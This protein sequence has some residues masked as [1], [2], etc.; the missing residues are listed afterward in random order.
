MCAAHG[1]SVLYTIKA[2]RILTCTHCG[3]AQIDPF[4]APSSRAEFYSSAAIETRAVERIRSRS[5]RV[6]AFVRHWLRR[7]SG[8]TK[9]TILLRELA[10]R[11]P[12][13]STLLDI[14]CGSGAVL[15]LACERYRCTGIEISSDLAAQARALGTTVEVGDFI[16]HSFGAQGFDAVTMVSLIEHLRDPV[17]ALRRCHALLNT[18]GVLILKTVNHGG[19]NRRLLGANW[20]GYR[21]P[22]HL[23]YFAPDT[24]R[25]AL[26][27]IG[28][29][30]ITFRIPLFN[31]SFYCYARK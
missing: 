18:S 28:F 13:G 17:L 5:A 6:T 31:D 9:G 22:D 27:Q 26:Q 2:W 3:F 29:R 14:G 7:L 24:L 10:R 23:I 4:P 19:V 21:P 30:D 8:R 16:D 11:V 15:R 25:R 1:W 12:V 20:S